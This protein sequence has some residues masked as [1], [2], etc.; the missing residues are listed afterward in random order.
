MEKTVRLILLI[1]GLAVLLSS[2]GCAICPLVPQPPTATPTSPP[3]TPTPRP[4]PTPPPTPTPGVSGEME[5]YTSQIAGIRIPYPQ[6]WV[7]HEEVEGVIFSDS[8]EG[9]E[10]MDAAESPLLIVFAGPPERI[11]DSFNGAASAQELLE[12]GIEGLCQEESC[13]VGASEPRKFG[14]TPG[15]MVELSWEDPYTQARIRGYLITAFSDAVAGIGVGFASAEDWPTYGPYLETML[16]GLEL[17]PPQ[18]P[19]PVE[20]GTISPGSTVEGTLPVGGTE[21]WAFEAKAG[22]YVS[23]VLEAVDPTL[24]PYLELYDKEG[25]TGA[26]SPIASDDDSGGESNSMIADFPIEATGTYYIHAT[27]Y[28]GHGDYRLTLTVSDAPAGGGELQYGE[29]VEGELSGGGRHA[30]TFMG[31]EGDEVSIAVKVLFESKVDP[32]VEL[33]SPDGELLISDDDSGG[34]FDA[35]IEYYL[36]PVSGEYRIMVSDVAR[37]PGTYRL[38]LNRAQLQIKGRLTY[39]QPA[40]AKLGAGERHNWQFEG[41]QGE[42]VTISMV[43]TGEWWDTYLELFAPSGRLLAGDFGSGVEASAAIMEFELP[44]TG[45]YRVLA[46]GYGENDAGAYR[47]TVERV[48]LKI[49]GRLSYGQ[50]ITATLEANTRHHWQFEGKEGDTVTISMKLLK[51]E[52][53]PHLEL[54]APGGELVATDDDS[55]GESNAEIYYTLPLTGVYRVVA[56]SYKPDAAGTYQ[57]TLR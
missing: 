37:E 31:R 27:P 30:W 35:L 41:K 25:H 51:G 7:Y 54:F 42:A 53:D 12:N 21:V 28:S 4:T 43:P 36:L 40:Q 26:G 33:Y 16:T 24:D 57:L 46:R 45:V 5:L 22:E 1:T 13:E 44:T 14:E 55:G 56:R 10:A 18:L 49:Q 38:T 17:F 11:S 29:E 2:L 6:D 34:G 52:L 50:T 3:A 32:Y 15:L 23:I 48:E 8:Q 47:I 39:G 20:R 19:E 9:L